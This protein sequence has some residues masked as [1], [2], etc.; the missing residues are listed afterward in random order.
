MRRK[1]LGLGTSSL[2]FLVGCALHV[3]Y[4]PNE[5]HYHGKTVEEA[6]HVEAS[7]PKDAADKIAEG[8]VG[9]SRT[10]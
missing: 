7:E 8:L 9:P 10:R 6:A 4:H 5:K 1:L 3:H 2:L